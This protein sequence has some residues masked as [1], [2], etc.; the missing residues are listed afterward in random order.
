MRKAN[1]QD[2]IAVNKLKSAVLIVFVGLFL[3]FIGWV[4]GE[5]YDPTMAYF[6]LALAGIFSFFFVFYSYYN[7][8]KIVLRSVK[9]RPANK[10]EHAY[11]MNVV[12]GLAI[13]AKIPVPRIYVMET[14]AINAFA[15][16][17]NP[18]N[19]VICV[20]T[21]MMKKL[22]R[23]E[24]EGVIAHEMSHI[25]NYDIRFATLVAVLVGI[26]VILSDMFRRNL[27]FSRGSREEKESSSSVLLIVGIIFALLAPIFVKIVQLAISR[28]REFLADAS[29]AYLTRYP[30]GLASALE[31]IAKEEGIIKVNGAV[32]PLFI[33]NPLKARQISNLFSTH[34]PIEERIKVLRGM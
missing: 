25:Q 10:K 5:V 26:V 14:D 9:A 8:D 1:I 4:L 15:T 23:S 17:R 27:W 7:S 22:N 29:G 28:K 34:P 3:L 24:I 11:L 21:G 31:K 19:S 30:E 18:E 2:E 20:T 6:F 16:G 32:A 13:A 33:S 12:E